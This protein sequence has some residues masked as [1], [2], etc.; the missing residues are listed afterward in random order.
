MKYLLL[1]CALL[2]VLLSACGGGG[3]EPV[4][5]PSSQDALDIALA[6][7]NSIIRPGR[8]E[9]ISATQSRVESW[10]WDWGGDADVF[11]AVPLAEQI[12]A[13]DA[14]YDVQTLLTAMRQMYGAY[15]Y[16]GG[17]SVFVPLF[18]EI[19]QALL[20]QDYWCTQEFST[21]V[22]DILFTIVTDNHFFL[23]TQSDEGLDDLRYTFNVTATFFS[24]NT[25]FARTE[26]GFFNNKCHRYVVEVM[27]HDLYTVFRLAVNEDG[28]LFYTPVIVLPGFGFDSAYP[29]QIIYEDG[30]EEILY[31]Y[32][33]VPKFRERETASLHWEYDIPV[34][35]IMDFMPR[36]AQDLE[37]FRQMLTF[38][39][40]VREAPAVIV[41]A[42]SN[43]GGAL[44][45][46]EGWIN[47]LVGESIYPRHLYVLA[48]NMRAI[49]P[50]ESALFFDF[51][52]E[53]LLELEDILSRIN[54]HEPTQ[55]GVNHF[56]GFGDDGEVIEREQLV[57]LLTDRFTLSAGELLTDMVFSLSNSLVIGQNTGGALTS[58]APIT[59]KALPRSGV[60]FGFGDTVF[61]HP[62]SHFPEGVG[63][64]PDIWATG[65][66]QKAALAL[67]RTFNP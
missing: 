62:A 60:Q 54:F 16:L 13:D 49:L 43:I 21:V 25:P 39:D 27:G 6:R 42:R 26:K 29:L 58:N 31:L 64:A 5:Y 12:S 50:P 37:D 19:E 44:Q 32:A 18:H 47:H 38:A 46:A 7:R 8:D 40:D 61:I 20:T 10:R 22:S 35:T 34:I 1:M 59:L 28:S 15:I 56:I 33:H 9:I 55:F 41:D 65:D 57:I 23:D 53:S 63:F 24:G 45:L 17:D 48:M 66:A 2:I 67:V 14:V 4:S 52:V 30:A 11:S 51:G 36:D 3:N